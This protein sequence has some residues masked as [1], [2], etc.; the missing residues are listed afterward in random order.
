MLFSVL[1]S[2]SSGNA[3][4]IEVG[5]FGVLVDIGLGPRQLAQR[6]ADAGA[7]WHHVH[8]VLLT[9]IHGDHWNERSLTHLC[10][11]GIP[12]FCHGEHQEM[13]AQESEAFHNLWAAGLLRTY[14]AEEELRLGPAL[15]CRPIPV[16]HDSG[17]TCGFRFQ[18]EADF[19]GNQWS[20]GYA[21]DLGTWEEPLAQALANVD[22]LALE[23]NHDV[24]MEL[25]SGRSP[26]LIARVLGD[27][28]H[29]SNAQA[30]DLVRQVV[31]CS[32]RGRLRHLVQLHLSREC[33]RPA[34]ARAAAREALAED[35]RIH[36][37]RQDRS[38]PCLALG[39]TR[40]RG[41]KRRRENRQQACFP[42]WE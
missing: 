41:K 18:G 33:N 25:S 19:F 17:M 16:R 2:G 13:L 11:R 32:E 24:D 1:A 37:A 3:S 10:R 35:V 30:A 5:G 39:R 21:T 27:A 4:L 31:S 38:G 22:I 36:S 42:G 40:K 12:L 26:E 6:L 34:L 8:A 15:G 28:G 23:F 14:H 7:S 29:L 20:L 9:H